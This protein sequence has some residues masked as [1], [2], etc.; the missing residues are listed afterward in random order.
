MKRTVTRASTVAALA[1]GRPT[2]QP[3]S[4]VT[5]DPVLNDSAQSPAAPWTVGGM[6][7]RW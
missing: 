6:W 1:D 7:T 3:I 5:V 4:P 2:Q